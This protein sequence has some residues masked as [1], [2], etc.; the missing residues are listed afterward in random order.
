GL[1]GIHLT[2][3]QAV[4]Q[5]LQGRLDSGGDLLNRALT[6]QAAASL[7]NFQIG[8]ASAM[9]DSRTISARMLVDFFTSLLAD[10]SPSDWL[11]N[12]LDAMAVV[13]SYQDAAFDRWFIATLERKD[14]VLALDVAERTKRRRYLAS[15]PFGA[16]LMALRA[17]LESSESSLS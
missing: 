11:R 10:P 7:R 13:A 9:Y 14:A 17:L 6:A 1:P 8:R 2:Y 5:I 12:P 16:R 4:V 15:Q 3:L